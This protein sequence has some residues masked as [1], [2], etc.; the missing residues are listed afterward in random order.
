[1]PHR[2]EISSISEG[3][4]YKTEEDKERKYRLSPKLF[5]NKPDSYLERMT[6]YIGSQE[7]ARGYV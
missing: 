5:S 2:Y 1:M 4:E 7:Q 6:G 3:L